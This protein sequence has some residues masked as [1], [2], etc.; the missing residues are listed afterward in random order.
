M[1]L[2]FVS[3]AQKGKVT[4]ALN[5]LNSGKVDKAKEAIDKGITHHKCVKWPK[6]YYAKGRV[7]QG[8]FESPLEAF[9]KLDNDPLN[10]SYAAFLKALEL[11][12]KGKFKKKITIEFQKLIPNFSKAAVADFKKKKFEASMN[13]F[14]KVIEIENHELYKNVAK[15]VI[16]TSTI[17]NVAMTAQKAKKYDIAIEYYKKA[18]GYNYGGAGLYGSLAFCYKETGKKDDALKALQ[19]GF[20]K[21]PSDQS[22]LVQLINHYLLGGDE[23]KAKAVEYIDI[24]IKQDPKNSSYRRAKGTLYEKMKKPAEAEKCYKE[25]I[26]INPD[27]FDARYALGTL[28]LSDVIAAHKKAQD[29][30]DAKKY[31]AAIDK[32]MEGYKTCIPYYEEARRIKPN[33]HNTLLTLKELYFKLR[34][35]IPE[36]MEK[37]KEVKALLDAK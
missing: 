11:D 31:N 16:D 14:L 27:D 19:D 30:M 8:I 34:V 1:C 4:S 6:A 9:R 10:K 28:K 25:A 5:Y 29:I 20:K 22:V 24:A 12:V 18:I 15:G 32:V 23:E 13:N 36:Y 2:A 35:K 3:N 7:Y 26:E 21:D 33:D 37:Y 17:Y